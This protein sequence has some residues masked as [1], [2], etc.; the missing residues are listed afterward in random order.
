MVKKTDSKDLSSLNESLS[1]L[2]ILST[3][4]ERAG[5]MVMRNNQGE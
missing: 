2:D 5:R 1:R 4:L 3:R